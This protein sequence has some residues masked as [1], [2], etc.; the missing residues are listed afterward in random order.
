LRRSAA[1]GSSASAKAMSAEWSWPTPKGQHNYAFHRA[2]TQPQL[3]AS[4]EATEHSS[5]DQEPA[6]DT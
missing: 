3:E 6:H 2:V 4:C 1:P 5:S